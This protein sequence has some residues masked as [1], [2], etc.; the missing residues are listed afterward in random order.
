MGEDHLPQ[1]G[2]TGSV[3]SRFLHRLSWRRQVGPVSAEADVEVRELN[4]EPEPPR[5]NKSDHPQA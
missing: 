5:Q 3:L 2:T 4:P 1:Q